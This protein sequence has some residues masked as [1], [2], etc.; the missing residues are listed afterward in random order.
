MVMPCAYIWC[1]V[2]PPGVYEVEWRLKPLDRGDIRDLMF[3]GHVTSRPE[4]E[5]SWSKAEQREHW[6]KNEFVALNVG[7]I[8]V[9]DKPR[10]CSL[11]WKTVEG[12][13]KE[14]SG[15][16]TLGLGPVESVTLRNVT[17]QNRKISPADTVDTADTGIEASTVD[18]SIGD[19]VS[20]Q[21]MEATL[22]GTI[23]RAR[24][25]RAVAACDKNF[26]LPAVNLSQ[27]HEF[28]LD[29]S[30]FTVL[31]KAVKSSIDANEQ[32]KID[33]RAIFCMLTGDG[34]KMNL[35]QLIRVM[36]AD[37]GESELS[38]LPPL[39]R[40]DNPPEDARSYS[41]VCMNDKNGTG[42]ARS[43]LNSVILCCCPLY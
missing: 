3:C 36:P 29:K 10:H 2:V 8:T 16:M 17:H 38:S 12:P 25:R 13:P 30:S 1:Q 31:K 19:A 7:T 28:A 21:F 11:T 22:T 26:P 32:R 41:S 23:T 14:D 6:G 4:F 9:S 35:V 5:F 15:S 34:A 42:H 18:V 33:H 20:F 24:G 43:M 40:F 27:G 39:A 37:A